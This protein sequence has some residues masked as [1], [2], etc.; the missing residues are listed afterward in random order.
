MNTRY[1]LLKHTFSELS[2][3]NSPYEIETILSDLYFFA[4]M[5]RSVIGE[6]FYIVT[7]QKVRRIYP[8]QARFMCTEQIGK[9]SGPEFSSGIDGYPLYTHPLYARFTVVLLTGLPKSCPQDSALQSI[10]VIITLTCKSCFTW[11]GFFVHRL[12]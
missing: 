7:S 5:I 10:K 1:T 9:P 11:K 3:W 12:G 2:F 8:L 6:I 4:M